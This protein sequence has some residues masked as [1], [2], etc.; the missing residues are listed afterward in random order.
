[1]AEFSGPSGSFDLVFLWSLKDLWILTQHRNV[2]DCAQESRK[3]SEVRYWFNTQSEYPWL[4]NIRFIWLRRFVATCFQ[5]IKNI[6]LDK[7]FLLNLIIILSK[8]DPFFQFFLFGDDSQMCRIALE[9]YNF[10]LD[11]LIQKTVTGFTTY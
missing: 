1:M 10:I 8:K 9:L 2:S 7:A 5:L 3:N 4:K 6:F 11:I